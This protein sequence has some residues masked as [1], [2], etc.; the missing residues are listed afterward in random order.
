[1]QKKLL[2]M[3]NVSKL[4]PGVKALDNVNLDLE[5]GEVLGLLGENGAGKSTMFPVLSVATYLVQFTF[6]APSS[7]SSF[8]G[9]TTAP[10]S[11]RSFA[12]SKSSCICS[13]VG[14]GPVS[15]A[16]TIVTGGPG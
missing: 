10:L 12:R 8:S 14:A 15:S 16:V 13:G 9:S 3:E 2:R 5:A 7:A 6:G 4:F 1:M 11:G